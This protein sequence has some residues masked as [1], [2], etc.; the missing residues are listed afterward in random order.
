MCKYL[1][2][3][4]SPPRAKLSKAA[5]VNT[6]FQR[7]VCGPSISLI[8]AW[9]KPKITQ[10][11]HAILSF[12]HFL[13]LHRIYNPM[14]YSSFFVSLKFIKKRKEKKNLQQQSYLNNVWSSSLSHPHT[15]TNNLLLETTSSSHR[16]ITDKAPASNLP[17][18]D[19][20]TP[21]CLP[22]LCCQ[23]GIFEPLEL[24]SCWYRFLP[25]YGELDGGH[26]ACSRG[27]QDAVWSE[28]VLCD[29][30]WSVLISHASQWPCSSPE[31][32]PASAAPACAS[33]CSV[34]VRL[35][36]PRSW[37]EPGESTKRLPN[38]WL[39]VLPPFLRP[40]LNLGH[41]LYIKA[42][43]LCLCDLLLHH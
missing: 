2:V 27:P 19:S 8:L 24:I 16:R 7:N 29:L 6:S 28:C 26:L 18:M 1:S 21:A 22:A 35:L 37:A 14:H 36:L 39:C 5:A 30:W 34:V 12:Y 31:A 20:C 9:I 41:S 38:W 25:G 3:G 4:M 32:Q 11:V 23:L 43:L 10:R 40:L 15:I 13:S 42:V 33:T 17:C